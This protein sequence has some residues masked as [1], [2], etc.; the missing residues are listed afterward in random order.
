[1][2]I[3]WNH[4]RIITGN[5]EVL[6]NASLSYE[7]DKILAVKGEEQ[8]GEIVYDGTGKTLI[9]GLFDCHVHLGMELPGGIVP[10]QTTDRTELGARI[11]KQCL[12]FPKYGIT[13]VRNMGT[14]QDADVTVKKVLEETGL[15]SVRILASGTAMSITGGHGNPAVGIDGRDELLKETRRKI[16]IGADVIKFVVTGGMGTKGSKPGMLQYTAEEMTPAVAEAS[17][18]GKITGAHCTSLEGAKEAIRA[19]IRSIEHAQFDE[20]TADLMAERMTA[21]KN[22]IFYCPTMVTRYTI[23]HNTNP[24]FEWLRKKAKP[25]DMERK[26]KA[27]LLCKERNIPICASTDANAPF[28]GLDAL[29]K[30]LELYVECGL[31]EMEAIKTATLN[32]SRLCMLDHVTGTLEAGKCADF[33][34]LSANPLENICNLKQVEQTY[35]NGRILYQREQ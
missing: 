16:K 29:L 35:R 28:A 30:E 21:G 24:E 32:A 11:M 25:G 14:E 33:V 19:G 6:E 27:V 7:G 5:G 9:P 17:L 34:V 3:V 10:Q 4:A 23:I 15:P 13:C 18:C 12:E 2:K 31:T 26:K 8:D 22:E 20:E 1:M